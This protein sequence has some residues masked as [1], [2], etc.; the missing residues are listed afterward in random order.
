MTNSNVATHLRGHHS[1]SFG[2]ES[3]LRAQA[4]SVTT[5]SLVTPQPRDQTMIPAAGTFRSS[6]LALRL[7]TFVLQSVLAFA[8][9]HCFPYRPI[10]LPIAI[11]SIVQQ[12]EI[13]TIPRYHPSI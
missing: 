3:A 4:F 9:K 1:L 2:D 10:A 7:A 13:I 11:Y 8:T 6:L 12:K 5:L